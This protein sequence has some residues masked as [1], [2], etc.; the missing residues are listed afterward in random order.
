[1]RLS[2]RRGRIPGPRAPRTPNRSHPPRVVAPYDHRPADVRRG[3]GTRSRRKALRHVAGR[4]DGGRLPLRPQADLPYAPARGRRPTEVPECPRCPAGG[5]RRSNAACLTLAT[6]LRRHRDTAPSS[7]GLR[8]GTAR[9][10]AGAVLQDSVDS[11]EERVADRRRVGKAALDHRAV[12]QHDDMPARELG[13]RLPD[14]REQISYGA[15]EPLAVS[16]DGL[17]NGM[18]G[19]RI[20]R[21]GIEEGASAEAG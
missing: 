5:G 12:P 2:Q 11:L 10:G 13:W 19:I 14:L 21:D 15:Q 1:M 4:C 18:L 20:L 17:V 7:G 6:A 9:R 16:E 3:H 8:P